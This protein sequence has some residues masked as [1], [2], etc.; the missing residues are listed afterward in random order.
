MNMLP[1]ILAILGTVAGLAGLSVI[2]SRQTREIV[3]ETRRYG[4]DVAA[5]SQPAAGGGGFRV[6]S[7]T[8]LR[9][10]R[11][12]SEVI[13]PLLQTAITAGIVAV[14]LA[15][16]TWRL[17]WS[18]DVPIIGFVGVLAA[19][20][21]WRLLRSDRLMWALER[22]TGEDLNHDKAIGK[23]GITLFNP[24][25]AR[26]EARGHAQQQQSESAKSELIAFVGRCAVSG[27]SEGSLGIAP[28]R[29]GDYVECRDALLHLGIAE[30]TD[31]QRRSAGWRLV[32]APEIAAQI[33]EQYV[34]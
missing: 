22:M 11:V 5:P 3:S 17:D 4:S 28:G 1:I 18:W 26:Q 20:W 30:W 14:G 27:T 33:I 19:M 7:Q 15:V 34:L 29:R 8:P 32:V 21:A 23:P 2:N 25:A 16:L 6:E 13:V 10:S 31:P 9:V 12:E 24:E